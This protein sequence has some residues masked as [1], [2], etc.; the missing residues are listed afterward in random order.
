[1]VTKAH[2]HMNTLLEPAR[3]LGRCPCKSEAL[4]LKLH[5]LHGNIPLARRFCVPSG[6]AHMHDLGGGRDAATLPPLPVAVAE[7][8]VSADRSFAMAIRLHIL[9]SFTHLGA[10]SCVGQQRLSPVFGLFQCD[11]Y[12]KFQHAGK[13]SIQWTPKHHPP[14]FNH[15]SYC[16][17]FCLIIDHFVVN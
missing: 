5:Y 11:F 17:I 13:K 12:L 3:G 1:M 2:D 14:T 7:V 9:Q 4:R 15:H 6:Q 16:V 10:I 8:P